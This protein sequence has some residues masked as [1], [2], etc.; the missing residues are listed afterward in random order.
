MIR[1]PLDHID[2]V[3]CFLHHSASLK[4]ILLLLPLLLS[5]KTFK[6]SVSFSQQEVPRF[7]PVFLKLVKILVVSLFEDLV[8]E[9]L[10]RFG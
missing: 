6:G 5:D 8:S 10:V 9:S 1:V 7:V 2:Q 3:A 4:I